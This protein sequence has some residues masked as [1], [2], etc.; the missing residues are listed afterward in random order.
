MTK[1]RL[2][3]ILFFAMFS[4]MVGIVSAQPPRPTPPPTDFTPQ[5]PT[6]IAPSPTITPTQPRIEATPTLRGGNVNPT[7]TTPVLASPTPDF[8][9]TDFMP[10]APTAGRTFITRENLAEVVLLAR[11]VPPNYYDGFGLVG[12]E[13]SPDG[14][15]ILISG[16]Q[17]SVHFY[18]LIALRRGEAEPLFSFTH[19]SQTV[20]DVAFHPYLDQFVACSADGF[21]ALKDFEG[22]SLQE[23]SAPISATQCN[24]SPKGDLFGYSGANQAYRYFVDAEGSLTFDEDVIY[25]ES[26]A[27]DVIFSGSGTILYTSGGTGVTAHAMDGDTILWRSLDITNVWSVNPLPSGNLLAT[28]SGGLVVLLDADG[29]EITRYDGHENDVIESAYS[30]DGDI[31]VTGS[32]DNNLLFWDGTGELT[33]PLHSLNHGAYIVDMAWSRDGALVASVG[34]NGHLLLWGIP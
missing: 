24:Y 27:H 18:D 14:R 2:L 20:W 12:V 23:I 6:P 7:P 1:K 31:L 8:P 34:N 28:G 26:S 21:I 30:P 22:N 3:I 32:W 10:L 5:P 17:G 15:Y 13:F 29:V 33:A 9:T 19:G 4:L 16:N 25:T 11:I